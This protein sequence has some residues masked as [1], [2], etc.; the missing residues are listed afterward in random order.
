MDLIPVFY[1]V[2]AFTAVVLVLVAVIL[3]A[4]AVFVSSG[5]VAITIND[6]PDN[7]IKVSSGGKLLTTLA[8]R[9]IF[10]PS[11]CGGGGTCGQ[12]KCKVLTGGG[13]LL[14]TERGQMNRREIRE[15]VRLSCQ[16]PVK[17]DMKIEVAP[18]IFSVK[19]WECTV[20]SNDNVATFIKELVLECPKGRMFSSRLAVTSR[21]NVRRMRFRTGISTF[22]RGTGPI[23]TSTTSGGTRA[24]SVNLRAGPIRWPTIPVKKGSSC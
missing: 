1:G 2:F 24:S 5:E 22:S 15:H 7:T 20:R 21:S 3:V 11:A 13:D 17:Q 12:C 18:E 19:K 8:D 9:G 4:K 10:I 16:V 23:G 14:P 6:D